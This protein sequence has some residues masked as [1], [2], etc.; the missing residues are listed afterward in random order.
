MDATS[1]S[2][3]QN[4]RTR[5]RSS[6]KIPTEIVEEILLNLPVK[7]LVRFSSV[8]KSWNSSIFDARFIRKHKNRAAFL[9]RHRIV[10]NPDY[11]NTASFC[12]ISPISSD[13][14]I[15]V[16][17]ESQ[18][19]SNAAF[20]SISSM[21]RDQTA[22]DATD[23][24]RQFQGKPCL[25]AFCDELWCVSVEVENSLFLWNPSMRI[26]RKL[27]N[28]LFQARDG[29][30][31]DWYDGYENEVA[32]GQYNRYDFVYGL[33]YDSAADDYKILKIA[34]M[35]SRCTETELYSLKSNCW[36]KIE[37]FSAKPPVTQE[38]CEFVDGSFHWLGLSA[39]HMEPTI[40]SF[41][42]LTE[43]YGEVAQ[44]EYS[45]VTDLFEDDELEVVA[46]RGMLCVR[47][48][49]CRETRFVLWVMEEYGVERSWTKKFDIQ[50]RSS[51][52]YFPVSED[53]LFTLKPLYFYDN[54]DLLIKVSTDKC[55]LEIF[56]YK[57]EVAIPIRI[58][59]CGNCNNTSDAFLY[60]ESLVSPAASCW[61]R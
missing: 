34:R 16:I 50:Y 18:N 2:P 17:I 49:Y 40:V 6:H 32:I 4:Q 26:H 3:Q 56:M 43:E 21:F 48:N 30:G 33:G 58:V 29:I 19:A 23:F 45:P 46:V 7:S 12:A 55:H 36:R 9:S 11:D 15:G 27:P 1:I 13:N 60:I 61:L 31:I 39:T 28:P 53:L 37:S 25:C 35:N 20:C 47:V 54:G 5:S 10:I 51:L 59:S 38:R 57:N 52:P 41:S 24:V 22:A 42:L 8:S 44:P 14:P